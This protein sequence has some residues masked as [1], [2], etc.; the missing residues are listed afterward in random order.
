MLE[1]DGIKFRNEEEY[2]LA[3]KDKKLIDEIKAHFDMSTPDGITA[4][5]RELQT[6]TFYS[7]LGRAFDDE[8]FEKYDLI[9][10]GKLSGADL[11]ERSAGSANAGQ[12]NR[13]NSEKGR[14]GTGAKAVTGNS[15][16]GVKKSVKNADK[17]TKDEVVL[18]QEIK[19]EINRQNRKRSFLVIL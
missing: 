2:N 15:A 1:I 11:R 9:K 3:L 4:I 19:D 7:D 10:A 8:I 5:Y 14:Q 17:K 12:G 13:L 6:K 18:T 16:K